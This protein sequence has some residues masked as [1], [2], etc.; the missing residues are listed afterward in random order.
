[1]TFSGS[2]DDRLAIRERM[3]AYADAV[4]RR[5]AEAWI[6]GWAEDASWSLMG[7]TLTG[8]DT[9]RTTW[10]GA[11][12]A[13]PLAAFFTQPGAIEVSGDRATARSFTQEVLTLSLIHI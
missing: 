5:D 10:E 12:A 6:A 8:R 1:M 11:M 13:F 4:F 7:M 9:I 2:T 3:E